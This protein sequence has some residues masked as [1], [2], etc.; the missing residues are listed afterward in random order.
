[1]LDKSHGA[2]GS[3]TAPQ[4]VVEHPVLLLSWTGIRGG[5]HQQKKSSEGRPEGTNSSPFVNLFR[6]TIL[7]LK[8]CLVKA[9]LVQLLLLILSFKRQKMQISVQVI[10]SDLREL[11]KI[12]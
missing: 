5:A 8:E 1:M 10:L 6:M 12:F 7:F 2:R 11:E 4:P 9:P 3:S